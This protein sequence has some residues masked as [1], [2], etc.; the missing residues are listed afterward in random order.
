MFAIGLDEKLDL[1]SHVLR[2]HSI[3][4]IGGASG[5]DSH[6]IPASHPLCGAILRILSYYK[7]SGVWLT[8]Q[9]ATSLRE[10]ARKS[11]LSQ[12]QRAQWTIDPDT[13]VCIRGHRVV[14]HDAPW[15]FLTEP[16]LPW[17]QSEVLVTGGPLTYH[18]VACPSPDTALRSVRSEE[19]LDRANVV[20][21]LV[22][23]G[24]L[25]VCVG[26]TQTDNSPGISLISAADVD[27]A[28]F[29]DANE[30]HA[31]HRGNEAARAW[32][33]ARIANDPERNRDD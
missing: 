16:A 20:H 31:V 28:A 18:S 27:P 26:R 24:S 6:G 1:H 30:V 21:W 11:R 13:R 8:C 22:T 9:D 4:W 32:S 25:A 12:L 5:E 10:F 23:T 14:A 19:L 7:F 17:P 15:P 29:V 33:Y 2:R 3:V